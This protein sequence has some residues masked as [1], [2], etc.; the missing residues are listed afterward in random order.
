[1]RL[2]RNRALVG[3]S[4][5]AGAAL[6]LT[7]AVIQ[8]V[9]SAPLSVTATPAPTLA[10]PTL[11]PA[12]VPPTVIAPAPPTTPVAPPV[13]TLRTP[14]PMPSPMSAEDQQMFGITNAN[15]V[16]TD[17]SKLTPAQAASASQAVK[18]AAA[19]IGI[20]A[21]NARILH[22]SVRV[23]AAEP[24]RSAWV[25]LFGGGDLPVLGPPGQSPRP[26]VARTFTG[27]VVDDTTGAV[28]TWFMR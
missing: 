9:W 26:L 11:A 27:V 14:G 19:H 12:A 23:I 3:I 24:D 7:L 21:A 10:A 15:D 20:Q 6:I 8:P 28:L 13:R 17:P 2:L 1:M 22:A 18:T 5:A 4:V 25:V 16:T